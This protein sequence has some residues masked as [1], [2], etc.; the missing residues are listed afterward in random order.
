MDLSLDNMRLKDTLGLFGSEGFAFTLPRSLP[1][2][3]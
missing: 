2:F 3:I 1:S